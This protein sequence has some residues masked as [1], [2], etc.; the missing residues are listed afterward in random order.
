MSDRINN[1]N[2]T[3]ARM[4]RDEEFFDLA[5]GSL[6]NV[7]KI[8]G[9]LDLEKGTVGRLLSDE[10]LYDE[11]SEALVKLNSILVKLMMEKELLENL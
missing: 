8:T 6:K 5:K 11:M 4:M 9:S 7:N 1:G 3:F 10:Q 2:G